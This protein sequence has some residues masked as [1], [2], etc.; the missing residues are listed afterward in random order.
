MALSSEVF[1]E[2]KFVFIITN[3]S[4]SF[5]TTVPGH[6]NSKSA[7]KTID[8]LNKLLDLRSQHD[9]DLHVEQV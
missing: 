7:E 1:E 6:W 4:N 2:T 9:I 3:E 8:E 5:S